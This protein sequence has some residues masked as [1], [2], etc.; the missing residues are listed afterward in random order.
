M[1]ANNKTI[2]TK[3]RKGKRD[4]K[5]HKQENLSNYTKKSHTEEI[6]EL[7]FERLKEITKKKTKQ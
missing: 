6:E 4:I 5:K 2:K 1:K 7:M 3:R